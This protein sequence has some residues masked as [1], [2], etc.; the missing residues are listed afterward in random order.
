MNRRVRLIT[1]ILILLLTVCP[2]LAASDK[3]DIDYDIFLHDSTL[4]IWMDLSFYLSEVN[5]EKL[6]EGIDLALEYQ[7]TLAV[8]KRFWGS[9][10]V[11]SRTE[12][13]KISYHRIT[14]DY[15][16]TS[17]ENQPERDRRFIAKEKLLQYLSDS[18]FIDL[19]PFDSLDPQKKYTLEIKLTGITLTTL[20]LLSEDGKVENNQTPLKSLFK[21]F[22]N[23]T[24]YGRKEFTVK[25]RPFSLDEIYPGP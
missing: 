6:T 21:Q 18:L 24:G 1:T 23:L 5:Q 16:L 12:I 15:L 10:T 3:N 22:L 20:N 7:L 2:S 19:A 17:T 8:P 14:E 4:T 25:S 11:A 9:N 13:V